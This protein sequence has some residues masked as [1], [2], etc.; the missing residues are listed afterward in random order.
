MKPIIS[1]CF[2]LTRRGAT[3]LQ[4]DQPSGV[5]MA[6]LKWCCPERHGQD[7]GISG[8]DVA[9]AN[10]N[11]SK[12]GLINLDSPFFALGHCSRMPSGP[13]IGPSAP[14]K[15]THPPTGRLDNGSSLVKCRSS[16]SI[17]SP[18]ACHS[19]FAMPRIF[20]PHIEA[21]QTWH[22]DFCWR[23]HIVN[24]YNMIMNIKAYIFR[25]V[26]PSIYPLQ[27][28]HSP[29]VNGNQETVWICALW[30][31][32]PIFHA[33]LRHL[34]LRLRAC[35]EMLL[36]NKWPY[37]I[38]ELPTALHLLIPFASCPYLR[39]HYSKPRVLIYS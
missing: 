2:A 27:H 16:N 30:S 3:G 36:N 34:V 23:L 14:P 29:R 18:W 19:T 24:N 32:E 17:H 5:S 33:P 4:S 25:M 38:N 28:Y 35:N 20:E 8:Y 12:Y 13:W 10:V 15:N 31:V 26:L 9:I 7:Q 1:S 22:P 11:L 6:T 39:F 37:W 21:H